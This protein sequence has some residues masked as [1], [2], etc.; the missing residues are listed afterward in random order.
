[1]SLRHALLAVLDAGPMTGYE[2]AKQF[3]QS[4]SQIWHAPHPQIYTELRKLERE[5]LV[6]ADEQLRGTKAVKRAYRLTAAGERE[7][8]R[9]ASEVEEPQRFRDAAYLKAS[10]FEYPEPDVV[11]RQFEVHR[12]CH[13][14]Q[15]RRWERHA[16]LLRAREPELL[17]KR[18]AG[19]PESGHEAIVAYKVH[20]YEGMAERARTEIA[21]AERGLALVAKM[22]G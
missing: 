4:A 18:L 7:L 16:E 10:Y 13:E 11:R 15:L 8:R 19:A 5:E 9:W 1:M 2:L 20:V 14:E 21:W 6:A 12:A 3:D 22:S 17:R